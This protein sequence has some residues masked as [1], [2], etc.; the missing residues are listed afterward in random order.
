MYTVALIAQ[1]GGTGKT[2]LAV[3]LAVAA[4]QVENAVA[5][6]EKRPD[7]DDQLGP[8]AQVPGRTGILLVAPA[9][10][11]GGVLLLDALRRLQFATRARGTVPGLLLEVHP[12]FPGAPQRRL[13]AR[14]CI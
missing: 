10:R 13:S 5:G 11:L 1:K 6:F 14:P 2:T 9:L 8:V 12:R 4:G 7:R 3:S